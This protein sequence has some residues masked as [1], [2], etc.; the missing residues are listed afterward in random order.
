[1]KILSYASA[2]YTHSAVGETVEILN[3]YLAKTFIFKR[4]ERE[5]QM[6]SRF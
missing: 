4:I 1:M 2:L 5:T 3:F 6:F